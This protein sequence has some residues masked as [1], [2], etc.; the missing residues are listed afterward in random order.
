[1]KPPPPASEHA[2]KNQP[3]LRAL[4]HALRER[5]WV[6]VVA[7]IISIGLTA[8]YLAR[9]PRTYAAHAVLQVEQEEQKV[10]NVQRIQQE[11]LQGLEW[12]RTIEQTL[13]SRSLL[14]QVL[15]T[16]AL[17]ADPRFVGPQS[18]AAGSNSSR[19]SPGRST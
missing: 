12:L 11:D 13:Q 1:M 18:P 3:D 17:A 10:L 19:N 14:G 6:I 9:T 7:I 16:L 8:F 5:C 15:D 4:D 2:V